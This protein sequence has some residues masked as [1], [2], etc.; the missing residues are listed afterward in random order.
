MES[1]AINLHKSLRW[2][3]NFIYDGNIV[4]EDMN[5]WHSNETNDIS[6]D[7]ARLVERNGRERLQVCYHAFNSYMILFNRLSLVET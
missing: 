3:N 7:V 5:F 4:M 1:R 2:G 6:T